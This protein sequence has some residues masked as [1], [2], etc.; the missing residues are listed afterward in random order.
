MNS[1]TNNNANCPCGCKGDVLTHYGK[2]AAIL[3]AEALIK[4]ALKAD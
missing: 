4:P 1:H 3:T 2:M